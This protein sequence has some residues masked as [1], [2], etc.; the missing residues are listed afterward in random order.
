MFETIPFEHIDGEPAARALTL[1]TLSTCA[2]CEQAKTFLNGR[3]CAY[4]R[5]VV[6]ELP[7]TSMLKIDKRALIRRATEEE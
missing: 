2:F 3:K 7:V 6:D 5:V 1:F 4:R